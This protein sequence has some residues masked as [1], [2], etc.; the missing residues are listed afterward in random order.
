MRARGGVGER[1]LIAAVGNGI[2]VGRVWYTYPINGQRAGDFT[3]TITGD[4]YLIRNGEI[5]APL[6]PN[7]LRINANLDEIFRSPVAIGKRVEPVTV[8]GS[9]EMFYVPA[10]AAE[11]LN[12]SVIGAGE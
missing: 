9:S 1:E 2:Y 4:S 6:R 10:M 8:W 11:A 5:A 7:A 12:L 3:C